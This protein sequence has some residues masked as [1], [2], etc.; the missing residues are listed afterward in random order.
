VEQRLACID[1]LT[2][3]EVTSEASPTG[4]RVFS[5]M[6]KQPV[7]HDAPN[8]E[9]FNQK[10]VLFH[11]SYSAPMILQTSGY[12]IFGTAL[13][14]VARKFNGNQIQVEH[15]F[16]GDSVPASL[17]WQKLDIRQSAADFH[18]IV[19]AFKPQY[20]GKW[21]NTGASK[22][23]MTSI[24]HKRFYPDDLDGTL[25]L[26][27]PLSYSTADERY[28]SFVEN[29]GGETYKTC[30]AAL[31]TFQRVALSRKSEILSR[32]RGAYS[33]LGSLE[34]GFEHAVFETPF[35]FWQYGN[36]NSSVT[37]CSKVPG[38]N[39]TGAELFSFMESVNSVERSYSDEGMKPFVS[40]YAQASHQLGSPAAKLSH[41]ADVAGFEDTY[42]IE[43]Y[44]P[45]EASRGFD[46][47]V[48]PEIQHW[49]ETEAEKVMF[50]YGEFDPW[51]AGAYRG[52]SADRDNYMFT[53]PGANHGANIETLTASDRTQAW[54][55]IKNWL[56]VREVTDFAL[57][58]DS[59]KSLEQI[60]FEALKGR[61]RL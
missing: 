5:I 29:V 34:I 1:G 44:I 20:G 21:L 23:G 26:V 39:A 32:I 51:T 43:T 45:Q 50:I 31:E 41:I 49:V 33:I 40:Y 60:E 22:G 15:R 27:A 36:P 4:F 28:V 38:P 25:A 13:T 52:G 8:G 24:F 2:F 16:F 17:D 18:R 37:G 11:R 12:Q 58:Q 57:F 14:N 54:N 53:A 59:A 7:D 46:E 48:M 10:L 61:G 56:N 6:F 47:S 9:T 42:R 55:V 19:Q 3:K 30:R 35:A